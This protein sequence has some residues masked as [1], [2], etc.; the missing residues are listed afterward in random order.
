[1]LGLEFD[2]S[3]KT[4]TFAGLLLVY[5]CLIS[6]FR[7]AKRSRHENRNFFDCLFCNVSFWYSS[8]P[9]SLS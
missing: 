2:F 9:V 1:M 8:F 7:R 4:L 3:F 6:D 5:D